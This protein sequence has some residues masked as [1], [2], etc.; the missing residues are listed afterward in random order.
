MKTKVEFAKATDVGRVRQLNEDNLSFDRDSAAFVLADGMGGHLA[1]EVASAMAVH[2]LLEKIQILATAA[3]DD[4]MERVL[5]DATNE[6]NRTIY[7]SGKS[8]QAQKGMGTTVVAGLFISDILHYIHVG[9]SRLYLFRDGLLKALTEDHSLKQEMTTLMSDS[10]SELLDNIPGNIVTQALGVSSHVNVSYG[11][12]KVQPEDILL[13]S[14]DGLHDMLD[15]IQIEQCIRSLSDLNKGAQQLIELANEAGG[16]DNIS[17]MLM[18]VNQS[19]GPL[20]QLFGGFFAKMIA[21][22]GAIKGAKK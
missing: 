22:K 19:K 14:S 13:A 12:L 20:L 21:Q 17:A 18:R 3:Q 6:V 10:A 8:N 1:G 9:D 4:Q 2:L 16:T 15:H 11:Y 7:E 5:S